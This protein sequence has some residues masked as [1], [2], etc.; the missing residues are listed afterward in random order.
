MHK[1]IEQILISFHLHHFAAVEFTACHVSNPALLPQSFVPQTAIFFLIP[2]FTGDHETRN[3]SLYA[4]P[5][6]Y[7]LFLREF[8]AE[9]LPHLQA[10]FPTSHFAGFGDHSPLDERH[11]CAIAGLGIYGDNGLLISKEYG[12]YQFLGEIL[13]DLPV[14]EVDPAATVHVVEHCSH[15]GACRRAC[16]MQTKPFGI[17]E[18]LSA[19]TQTKR[20]DSPAQEEQALKY[21]A[22]YHTVWGCD[23]C[24]TACPNNQNVNV[25]PIP[26][27]WQDRLYHLDEE[28]LNGM[29]TQTFRQRAYAWRGRR[30]ITRNVQYV[31]RCAA[32]KE[33]KS[34]R[35]E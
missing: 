8:F 3:V 34:D 7:H 33:E 12:T 27:F 28:T 32:S 16:P 26:F 19:V 13:T 24:Q 10:A 25:T 17:S 5:R 14:S 21:M 15:C 31:T 9:A 20:F 1:S 30:C 2:Y 29:D 23:L 11:G 6:D 4:V 35:E 22:A 18:C